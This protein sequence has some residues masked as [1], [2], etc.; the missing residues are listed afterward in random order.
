MSGMAGSEQRVMVILPD[1][2]ALCFSA[3]EHDPATRPAKTPWPMAPS[4]QARVRK[5]LQSL[6]PQVSKVSPVEAVLQSSG[7]RLKLISPPVH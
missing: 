5:F 3:I 7:R 6:I 2:T 1:N 4:P